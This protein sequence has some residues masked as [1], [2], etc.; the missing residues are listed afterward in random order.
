[1]KS[2]QM[3]LD[4]PAVD[5]KSVVVQFDGGD[6]TSD[7]GVLLIRDVDQ[8]LGISQALIDNFVDLR[9]QGKVRHSIEEMIRT[10]VYAITQGYSTVRTLHRPAFMNNP[11]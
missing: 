11:G 5:G 4:F 8:R 7:A 10:R 9:D 6:V 3:V 2:S 1:M